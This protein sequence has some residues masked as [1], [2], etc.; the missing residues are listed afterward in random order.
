MVIV[1]KK[2][3]AAVEPA[4]SRRTCE[5]ERERGRE[6]ASFKTVQPISCPSSLGQPLV[7]VA[8][9]RKM[10]TAAVGVKLHNNSVEGREL[11][12]PNAD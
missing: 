8:S 10:G 1:A 11:Q 2:R 9:P 7:V 3:G 5:R 4:A 12:P 6:G